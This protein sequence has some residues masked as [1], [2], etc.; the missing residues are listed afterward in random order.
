MHVCACVC[1]CVRMCVRWM[2]QDAG[3]LEARATTGGTQATTTRAAAPGHSK[4]TRTQ[5]EKE[6]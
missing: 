2:A 5:Y 4:R 6:N 3:G 1:M